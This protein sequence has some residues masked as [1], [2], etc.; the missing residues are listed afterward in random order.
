MGLR[1]L[2]GLPPKKGRVEAE[3][4]APENVT[5][6]PAPAVE[7]RGPYDAGL[8]KFD[9]V[10]NHPGYASLTAEQ[11]TAF[12]NA[13]REAEGLAANDQFAAAA[14]RLTDAIGV[15]AK[16]IVLTQ[17]SAK[18]FEAAKSKI[19]GALD[20]AR[21]LGVPADHI[22]LLTGR[23]NDIVAASGTDIVEAAKAMG[24][25][26]SDLA[27]DPV[28]KEARA[29]RQRVLADKDKVEAAAEEALK[30]PTETPTVLK[31][32]RILADALSKIGFC[33]GK[34]DYIEAAR[35]MGI[36]DRCIVAINS[37]KD[38]IDAARQLREEVERARAAINAD[39]TAA[40]IIYG[41]NDDTTKIVEKF[42]DTDQEFEGAMIA[43]DY[44][45]AK[46]LLP[47]LGSLAKQVLAFEDAM[48]DDIALRAERKA[49]RK[50]VSEIVDA[51]RAT[52]A[53]TPAMENLRSEC[54]TAVDDFWKAIENEDDAASIA[55][56]DT[57]EKLLVAYN[58]AADDAA[59]E[60]EKERQKNAIWKADCKARY[61]AMLLLKPVIPDMVSAIDAA[62]AA[63]EEVNASSTAGDFSTALDA[64]QRLKAHLDDVDR[65]KDAN[66]AG[67]RTRNAG[68][69]EYKKHQKLCKDA[70]DVKPY[71]E[72]MGRLYKAFVDSHDRFHALRTSGDATWSDVLP[73][74]VTNAR[75]VLAKVDE[76]AAGETEAEAAAGN[77][78]DAA[79]PEYRR[80]KKIADKYEPDSDKEKQTLVNVAIKFNTAFQAGRFIE[81]MTFL[82]D[83]PA[84]VQA[85]DDKEPEWKAAL[86]EKKDDYEKEA[87]SL[88]GDYDTVISFL[89]VLPG[90]SAQVEE[91]KD[92]RKEADDLA[93]KEDFG[94]AGVTQTKLAELVA[95][96]MKRKADHDQSV[97]DKAWVEGRI[98]AIG[99]EVD[100]AIAAF[101][102]LPE[103]LDIQTRMQFA[104]KTAKKA[105]IALDFPTARAQWEELE[106]LL[107]AWDD[108]EEANED[109]WTDEAKAVHDKLTA[110]EDDTDIADTIRGITP[111]LKK[112][113]ADYQKA[114]DA[115]YKAY[116]TRDWQLADSL[117]AEFSRTARLLA[118]AKDTFDDALALAG[119]R[120]DQASRTL[121]D[122]GPDELEAKS[123]EEKLDLLDGLR[124]T[125]EP[126][127]PEER[128]L[129]RKLYNALDYDP[130]FKKVDEERRAELVDALKADEDVTG[131]RG[132]WG[133]MT[134][135]Q[136]LAVLVKVLKAE[137]KVY[138]IPAPAVRLFNEPPGDEGFFA[139][140]TM[141]LNLN[142][143]PESGW[144]DYKEAIDTVI[145]ENMH[146]YQA[147]LVQRLEE[148]I[149]TKDDPEYVQALIFAANDAPDGYVDTDEKLDDD[150][151]GTNPYK[152]QPLEAHA[153][154]TGDGVAKELVA[155]P[156]PERGVR[157]EE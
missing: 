67:S 13:R 14:K 152:T 123:T 140:D 129:Q 84:A 72:E 155:G 64:V 112:L 46:A 4:P 89:P 116:R 1:K 149:I 31:Q 114:H 40:R 32:N 103:T 65:H 34:L 38:A 148:G 83:L 115:F 17:N 138:D 128:K 42:R 33:A 91:A 124:A 11:R 78:R 9:Q 26:L 120:K 39:V 2:L 58:S 23:F 61:S 57:L 28:I 7:D 100:D 125:G 132:T 99:G 79:L 144:S 5:P 71:T 110:F 77:A 76:N 19:S 153:W 154:D 80:A 118:G 108:K 63:F 143:H 146:N 134:D 44:G 106:R 127:T 122:I 130:E 98:A 111:E 102:L 105:V 109:A 56:L 45:M 88:K 86:G 53:A 92:L 82:E 136:R 135:D 37:E 51:I 74:V 156:P 87:K 119:P 68:W 18:D 55:A 16:L 30:V 8:T 15:T 70:L 48:D 66:A 142:T 96:M 69:A 145:H 41:T 73:D 90:L 43:R 141:T 25:L 139:S 94:K 101:A 121:T 126:L 62:K 22:S 150:E 47:S 151:A 49:R 6:E 117:I 95:E 75:A 59:D 137:C 97:S 27:K 10:A 3:Q 35:Y 60:L 147:V 85:I 157:L 133:Q 50:R 52:P 93:K 12:E 24:A 113:V 104:L 29:A 21:L 20:G 107:Q 36:C 54:Q 131:A 81:S